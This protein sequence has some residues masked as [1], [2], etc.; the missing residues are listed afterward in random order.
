MLLRL[1]L[2]RCCDLIE[3]YLAKER[4]GAVLI[5]LRDRDH[6]RAERIESSTNRI[7]LC[8][9][10]YLPSTLCAADNTI[11]LPETEVFNIPF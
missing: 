5:F 3:P 9:Y 8:E 4:P 10:K 11:T 7:P 2:A 6:R 1:L